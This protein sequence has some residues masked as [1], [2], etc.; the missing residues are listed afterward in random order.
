MKYREKHISCKVFQ[1]QY[2]VKYGQKKEKVVE[3]LL[4][5]LEKEIVNSLL[6]AVGISQDNIDAFRD[7]QLTD[8]TYVLS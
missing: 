8:N 3:G 7:V 4:H 2:H 6:H 5:S 1:I